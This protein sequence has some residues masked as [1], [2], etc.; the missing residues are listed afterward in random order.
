MDRFENFIS[1]YYNSSYNG[2]TV[3]L[4]YPYFCGL[5]V[6]YRQTWSRGGTDTGSSIWS[7]QVQ[8]T[9]LICSNFYWCTCI[10]ISYCKTSPVPEN[11]KLPLRT[12]S[13]AIHKSRLE[14]MR[15]PDARAAKRN[16]MFDPGA[17][18]DEMANET[19]R[20]NVIEVLSLVCPSLEF[21]NMTCIVYLYI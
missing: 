3:C 15:N 6:P 8:I 20:L 14:R 12:R 7:K 10:W 1:I 17:E 2:T 5:I 13:I 16:T 9:P 21:T 4:I 11:W 18:D 19:Q